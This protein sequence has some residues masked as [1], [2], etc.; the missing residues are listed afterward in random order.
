MPHPFALSAYLRRSVWSHRDF[1]K[2]WAAVTTSEFGSHVTLLALPLIAILTL[3]A[4]AFEVAALTAVEFLPWIV[5]SLPAGVW[6]DRLPRRS[7][8]IVADVGR[9]AALLSIPLAYATVGLGLYH[10]FVVAAIHGALTV[11]FDIAHRAYLPS[12][13]PRR[14]LVDANAKLE[15][16]RSAAEI[17]GPAA[18]GG[19]IKLLTAPV[20]ILVDVASFTLS[21]LFLGAIRPHERT[22]ATREEAGMLAQIGGGLR[23]VFTHPYLRPLIVFVGATNFST[24]LVRPIFILYAIRELGLSV[25]TIGL[26]FASGNVGLVL[27]AAIANSIP[28]R[29]GAGTTIVAC[30][31]AGSASMLFVPLAA[32]GPPALFL[33]AAL[34]GYGFFVVI[35]NVVQNTLTQVVTPDEMLGRVMASRRLFVWGT[36]PIGSLAS[37][38]LASLVGLQATTWIGA[39]AALASGLALIVSPLGALRELPV[40]DEEVELARAETGEGKY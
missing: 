26:V 25:A 8:M 29:I 11:F 3:D 17:A 30:G 35:F 40:G 19:L 2:L 9:A 7:V 20:A 5:L 27:G 31:A 10:L 23:F 39:F 1:T 37:G 16:S 4:S 21:A 6:V 28:K 34:F 13:V 24:Y 14:D 15:L 22:E 38:G 33:V 18:A 36:I 12:L 32:E